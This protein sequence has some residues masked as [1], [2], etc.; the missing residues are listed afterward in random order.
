MKTRLLVVALI[1]LLLVSQG[2]GQSNQKFGDAQLETY[3]RSVCGDQ[4]TVG[5]GMIEGS[6]LF[7]CGVCPDFTP[8]PGW[9]DPNG[10]T[11]WEY[12]DRL[13]GRFSQTQRP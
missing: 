3:L 5:E 11:T 4:L 6:K 2:S 12:A 7:F 13:E 9:S 8:A 1:T 10:G